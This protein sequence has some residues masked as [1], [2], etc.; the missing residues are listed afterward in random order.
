MLNIQ[1]PGYGGNPIP[2]V[3]LPV[4]ASI[5]LITE[6]IAQVYRSQTESC[7]GVILVGHS[8]GAAIALAIA[9]QSDCQFPVIGVSV[10]GVVPTL[11]TG[12]LIPDPDPEPDNLRVPLGDVPAM[13]SR[14]FGPF[15]CLDEKVFT[16]DTLRVVF[17][18][19]MA[20]MSVSK[21]KHWLI[22]RI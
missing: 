9:A 13:V 7:N 20:Q 16:A 19:G 3:A 2:T 15:E 11:D 8:L 14:F 10:L 4:L 18:P 12:I 22:V 21:F 17:E 1:R 5:P 6:L